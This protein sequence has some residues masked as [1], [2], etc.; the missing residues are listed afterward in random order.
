MPSRGLP[1]G[2]QADPRPARS[3]RPPRALREPRPDGRRHRARSS[4]ACTCT[5]SSIATA[6]G[7]RARLQAAV[8][9]TRYAA[10]ES[11]R[12]HRDVCL[13]A[14]VTAS[15]TVRYTAWDGTPAGPADGRAGIREARRST[16][17]Y[18]DDV[19]QALDWLL[20]QGLDLRGRAGH[21]TRRLPR[22]AARGD[23]RRGSASSTST[24]ARRIRSPRSS[25]SCS[26]SS[27]TRSIEQR[28][29]APRRASAPC[30]TSLPR[31]LSEAI[32]QLA[33]L[34]VRGR[35]R[36][37]EFESPRSKSS[38]TSARL[39]DFQRR[40]GELFQGPQALDYDAG[41]RAH[42]RDASA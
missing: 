26:T 34:R 8:D 33:R 29:R 32:E 31:R 2:R 13:V 7:A 10:S 24:G 3:R 42:A 40:Y 28:R 38:T 20:R 30:S 4:R 9:W 22:A 36:A 5:R 14:T 19:Q 11:M 6:R 16:C 37:A 12:R 39:E 1:R 17:R 27:A 15:C 35:G 21:G 41:G 23:A 18:T 25:R